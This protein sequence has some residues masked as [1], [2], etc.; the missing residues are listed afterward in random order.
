MQIG[1]LH[2]YTLHFKKFGACKI[3]NCKKLILSFQKEALIDQKWQTFI[4]L[5][6][7]SISNKCCYFE[8]YIHQRILKKMHYSVHKNINNINAAQNSALPSQG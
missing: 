1:S 7:L 6:K 5:Q 2:I 4:M 3:F 8:L